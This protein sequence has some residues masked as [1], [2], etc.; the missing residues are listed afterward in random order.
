MRES[1]MPLF[2]L[3][4]THNAHRWV[5]PV[6]GPVIVGPPGRKFLF[7]G[8]GLASAITAMERTT[9]RATVWAAAQYLSY[10]TPGEILDIDV[11]VPKSG[12][13]V[14]QARAIGH[15][16]DR[17]IFTV[18]AALG[19]RPSEISEAFVA[20]APAPDPEDCPKLPSRHA[21]NE[22]DMRDA[23]DLRIAQGSMGEGPSAPLAGD[24][25]HMR[26]WAR[27]KTGQAFDSGLLAII[28]DFVLSATSIALGRAAGANSLD[29]TLRVV[30]IHPTEWALCDLRI[31]AV[32]AGFVHGRMNIFSRDG[33]LM[34]IA[35]QSAILRLFG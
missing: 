27:A 10:A 3:R 18:N 1:P 33:K 5:L 14:T 11:I 24:G 16:Q 31:N 22:P 15:V 13:H 30:R 29:N 2:D 35:S 19:A 8:V 26:L 12:N 7:G 28:A 23:V 4:A 25:A 21:A 20:A 17:E 34:A 32:D 6:E 9:G